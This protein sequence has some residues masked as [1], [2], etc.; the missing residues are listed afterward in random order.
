VKIP[1]HHI[2][3]EPARERVVV[4]VGDRVIA[5]S[6]AALALRETGYPVRYYLP[7]ADVDLALLIR[8][9]KRTHCPFKGDASYYNV[10]TDDGEITDALWTYEQPKAD[11]ADIAGHVAFYPDKV[12]ITV[13]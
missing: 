10:A 2:A 13:E 6:K 8:S 1:G 3:I 9:Q 12:T 11:V 7:L 4:R 5:D